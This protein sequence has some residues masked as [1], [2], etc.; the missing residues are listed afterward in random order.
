VEAAIRLAFEF[1]NRLQSSTVYVLRLQDTDINRDA[2]MQRMAQ[3]Y[4]ATVFS[5]I[6]SH[7]T[8]ATS[9]QPLFID[10]AASEYD[11]WSDFMDLLRTRLA[12]QQII[13][14]LAD[15]YDWFAETLENELQ[16]SGLNAIGFSID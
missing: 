6:H 14:L 10:L 7:S 9:S 16:Q 15:P 3:R 11:S 2:L 8:A 12:L 4:S 13:V 1:H 5:G